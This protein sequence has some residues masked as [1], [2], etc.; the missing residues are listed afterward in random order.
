MGHLPYAPALLQN[1]SHF[2]LQRFL[3]GQNICWREVHL[4]A[5]WMAVIVAAVVVAIVVVVDAGQAVVLVVPGSNSILCIPDSLYELSFFIW[6]LVPLSLYRGS[7][8]PE[9]LHERSCQVKQ[10]V[11]SYMCSICLLLQGLVAGRNLWGRAAS[12]SGQA[13]E[14]NEKKIRGRN[15]LWVENR[16]EMHGRIGFKGNSYSFGGINNGTTYS[17]DAPGADTSHHKLRWLDSSHAGEAWAGY[18]IL[19]NAHRLSAFGAVK[20]Q[21]VIVVMVLRAVVRTQ[22]VFRYICAIKCLVDD[23][24]ILERAQGA[25]KSDPVDVAKWI[26]NLTLRQSRVGT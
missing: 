17:T 20:V 7:F 3:K 8:S 4:I 16:S 25:V 15:G 2:S 22:G 14:K 1:I 10:A 6:Q 5:V 23:P 26:L 11:C 18:G 24:L 13:K 21:M 9:L 19:I 12:G